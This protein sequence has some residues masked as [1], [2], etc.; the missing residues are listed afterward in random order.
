M[1]DKQTRRATP[2]VSLEIT[3][4]QPPRRR[5]L[6]AEERVYHQGGGDIQPTAQRGA[7]RQGVGRHRGDEADGGGRHQHLHRRPQ[8]AQRR[9]RRDGGGRCWRGRRRRRQTGRGPQGQEAEGP[10]M[11]GC[12]RRGRPRARRARC[13]APCCCGALG[14]ALSRRVLAAR[15]PVSLPPWHCRAAGRPQHPR[16]MFF[17]RITAM[18]PPFGQ[19]GRRPARWLAAWCLLGPTPVTTNQLC[20][21]SSV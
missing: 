12:L 18:R 5:L 9:S 15:S 4:F 2:R 20:V 6:D 3:P 17:S 10:V 21:T 19:P 8:P 13:A 16:H 1:L 11:R 7:R 14:G